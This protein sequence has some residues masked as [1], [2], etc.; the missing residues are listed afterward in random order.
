MSMPWK[1]N[2]AARQWRRAHPAKRVRRRSDGRPIQT[3]L[4]NGV[5]ALAEGVESARSD[6]CQV[7]NVTAPVAGGTKSKGP[8]RLE[9]DL[10]KGGGTRLTRKSHSA[11]VSMKILRGERGFGSSVAPVTPS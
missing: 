11:D 2:E 7:V 5:V 1:S 8:N 6:Y 10:I 9:F 3:K 4:A